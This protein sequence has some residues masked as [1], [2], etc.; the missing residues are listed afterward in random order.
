VHLAQFRIRE[1]IPS[2]ISSDSNILPQG[3]RRKE[4]RG[5]KAEKEGEEMKDREN[6]RTCLSPHTT[7]QGL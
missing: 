2:T 6:R 1:M 7:T 3:Q 4:K 5:G